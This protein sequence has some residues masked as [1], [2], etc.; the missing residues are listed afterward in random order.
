MRLRFMSDDTEIDPGQALML[1]LQAGDASAF[2]RLVER[3]QDM[4]LNLVFKFTGTR[5]EAEDLAQEV[6]LRVFRA[7]ASYQPSAKFTTWLYRIVFNL[8][9]NRGLREKHRKTEG[10]DGRADSARRIVQG[11][12]VDAD[13]EPSE[14]LQKSELALVVRNAVQRL[15][16]NQRLALVLYKYEE[17][18]QKE[19]AEVMGCSEKAIKSLLSRAREN[20]RADLQPFLER[21]KS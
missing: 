1:A 13:V 16:E 9:L 19:I 14:R 5:R 6:F 2:E 4:V 18:S 7:R 20:L 15:P 12:P 8:C 17:R 21:D 11:Q 10:L 3:F